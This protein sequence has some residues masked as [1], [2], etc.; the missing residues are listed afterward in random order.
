MVQELAFSDASGDFYL[1]SG[2]IQRD[3]RDCLWALPRVKG[4]MLT[5]NSAKAAELQIMI[6]LLESGWQIFA[7]MDDRHGT[8][9]VARL[10]DDGRLISI[11][12]KHKQPGAKNEGQLS[13]PWAGIEPP[14]DLLVFYQPEKSRGLIIPKQKLKKPG[15]MFLFFKEAATGYSSGSVRPL[16]ADFGF[17]FMTIPHSERAKSFVDH[18]TKIYRNYVRSAVGVVPST[19]VSES[20]SRPDFLQRAKTVWGDQP[21]G[22]L[23]SGLICEA[24]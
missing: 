19:S 24:R 14:F 13:N 21:A 20:G 5:G 16:Y 8:D 1:E 23:P 4:V 3:R 9:L 10:P 15:K 7:P 17:D 2:R 6:W 11:Q 12:V 22:I 18:L